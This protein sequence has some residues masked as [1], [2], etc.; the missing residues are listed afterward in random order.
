M[1]LIPLAAISS[2]VIAAFFAGVASILGGV[3]TVRRA[4]KEEQERCDQRLADIRE[5]YKAGMDTG[6]KLDERDA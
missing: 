1:P 3:W 2:E 6:L 5:A 4:R